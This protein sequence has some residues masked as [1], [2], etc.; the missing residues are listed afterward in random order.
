MVRRAAVLIAVMGLLG[1]CSGRQTPPPPTASPPTPDQAATAAQSATAAVATAPAESPTAEP[2]P[3]DDLTTDELYARLDP[4]AGAEPGCALPCYVGLTPGAAGL[5]DVFAFYAR[6]GVGREDLIPG[7][8]QAA[9][10]GTGRLGA[11]LNKATDVQPGAAVPLV[12]VGVEVGVVQSVYVGWPDAPASLAPA[13]VFAALG[14]PAEADLAIDAAAEAPTYLL[15]LAYPDLHS[16]FAFRGPLQAG[17]GTQD[18]CPSGDGLERV[19]FGT[20]APEQPVMAGLTGE[21]PLLPLD[22]T[23]GVSYADLSALAAGGGCLTLTADQVALWAAP[24]AE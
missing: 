8:L 23:L 12:D 22:E 7:D 24:G 16:G 13:A 2:I 6:L 4:L 11:G 18:V 3:P 20:F 21:T 9:A 10:D 19:F 17:A 15:R 14:E 1:A 5:D